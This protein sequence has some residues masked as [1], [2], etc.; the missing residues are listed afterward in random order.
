MPIFA[1]LLWIVCV[2]SGDDL[3][4]NGQINTEIRRISRQSGARLARPRLA[5]FTLLRWSPL[6]G[7]EGSNPSVSA[8]KTPGQPGFFVPLAS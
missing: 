7:T 6:T 3:S 8:E 1:F 4:N 2:T 5:N